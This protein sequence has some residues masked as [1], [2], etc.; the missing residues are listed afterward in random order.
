[1]AD[2]IRKSDM[3]SRHLPLAPCGVTE[4]GGDADE[5]SAG[6]VSGAIV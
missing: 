4:G 6:E 3:W 2:K 1:M 5:R